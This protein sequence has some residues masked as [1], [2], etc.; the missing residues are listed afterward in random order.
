MNYLLKIE[1]EHEGNW[2][3]IAR[4]KYDFPL[5][6]CDDLRAAAVLFERFP[7]TRV[8]ATLLMED[9]PA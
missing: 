5:P 6:A 3:E 8:R 7:A 9:R 1:F 4:K 2:L